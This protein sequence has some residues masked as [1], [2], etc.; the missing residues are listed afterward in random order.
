MS[1]V[2]L[3]VRAEPKLRAAHARYNVRQVDAPDGMRGGSNRADGEAN[4]P[5][6]REA[7]ATSEASVRRTGGNRRASNAVS[8]IAHATGS[9]TSAFTSHA[10]WTTAATP[11]TYA[12]R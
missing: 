7:R 4:G 5:F 3:E 8:P 9:R 12:S 11:A 2:G 10:K 6:P 1:A